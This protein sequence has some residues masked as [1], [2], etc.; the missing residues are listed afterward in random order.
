MKTLNRLCKE[1]KA[2]VVKLEKTDNNREVI[3]AIQPNLISE[4]PPTKP[5]TKLTGS[6]TAKDN[7][8][9]LSK[10]PSEQSQSSS[11]L[12]NPSAESP[13]RNPPSS[14]SIKKLIEAGNRR[15]S[16]SYEEGPLPLV[17]QAFQTTTTAKTKLR[18]D[19]QS[20]N[21]PNVNQTQGGN[22]SSGSSASVDL[23]SEK[24]IDGASW[25]RT[26]DREPN[27][28]IRRDKLDTLA[29][30]LGFE[31]STTAKTTL[32]QSN[33]NGDAPNVN[34]KQ[35]SSIS[36]GTDIK[37]D[38]SSKKTINS[39]A[40]VKAFTANNEGW[41][42]YAKLDTQAIDESPSIELASSSMPKDKSSI[43]T[44]FHHPKM[45]PGAGIEATAINTE[46]PNITVVS[47]QGK[48]SVLGGNMNFI[49]A[50]TLPAK[51]CSLKRQ[52]H[53]DGETYFFTNT[54]AIVKPGDH[55]SEAF[56]ESLAS[57]NFYMVKYSDDSIRAIHDGSGGAVMMQEMVNGT[58]R[59]RPDMSH[60]QEL[61]NPEFD[62]LKWPGFLKEPTCID[63]KA[64]ITDIYVVAKTA[65]PR[66]SRQELNMDTAINIS[67]KNP[68][69]THIICLE[70]DG[71]NRLAI[72]VSA[73]SGLV[74]AWAMSS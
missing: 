51:E 54:E 12:G 5:L 28:W 47:Y 67:Q 10:P 18:T 57:C 50:G 49:Y 31:T 52:K 1:Y 20:S 65:A 27:G 35:G 17:V 69:N 40:W 56:T 68:I 61:E 73:D 7:S 64:V 37:I 22:I 23:N 16:L 60:Y 46:V 30:K 8:Q 38:L 41:I 33:Q 19:S 25:L 53:V 26:I 32:R 42:R 70:E 55:K 43:P 4:K 6:N 45:V 2:K 59:C 74:T 44:K 36:S 29:L 63:S 9:F 11:I 24:T 58:T 71:T 15:A 48:R 3:M 72:H 21:C 13:R 39:C 62:K 14:D 34:Q 66:P